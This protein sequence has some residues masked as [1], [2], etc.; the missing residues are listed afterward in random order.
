MALQPPFPHSPPPLGFSHLP[1]VQPLHAIAQAV[2]AAVVVTSLAT[3][4]AL[5]RTAHAQPAAR[6]EAQH[7]F[8]IPA[9]PLA[10]ALTAFAADAGV[11]VSAP[12]ALVQGKHTAGLQ[13][14]YTVREALERLLAG[15]NLQADA[16]GQ[17]GYVLRAVPEVHVGNAAAGATLAEVRV[18]A[19]AERLAATEG[20]G[21]YT[22]R[23]SST[24]T[25]LALSLRETPQSVTVFTRQRMDDQG[26]VLQEDMV[27]QTTGLTFAQYGPTGGD[28][29]F[30]FARGFQV[31]NFQVDGVN[32]LFS[33]YTGIFQTSDMAMFDRAE[34]VRGASGLMSGAGTPGA[35]IN[36]V[37]KRPTAE[38]LGSVK[39]TAGSWDFGRAE[40]DVSSPLN[41]AGSVRGRVV[42]VSQKRHSKV[43]YEEDKTSSLYGV[44]EVDLAPATLAT[45]GFS[46]QDYDASGIG[47]SGRPLFY[48]D[49]TRTNWSRSASSGARW[50]STRRDYRSV[51]ASLEHRLDNGWHLK[52]AYTRD[53]NSY[54]EIPGWTNEQ[55]VDRTTGA[56]AGL[57]AAWWAGR[58]KQDTLDF[59]AAGPF[60]LLGRQH[61][62]AFGAS[63]ARTRND[64]QARG[65]WSF[66]GWDSSIANLYT[67]DGN[68][69]VQPDNPALG[70]SGTRE[71]SSSAYGS[72]R[73]RPADALSV[74]LGARLTNWKHSDSYTDYATGET[75]GS[76]MAENGK[77]TPYVGVVLDLGRDWSLYGSYTDIFQAQSAVDVNGRTLAPVL[78]RSYELGVK[79]ELLDRR[80]QLSAAVYRLLQDN[81]AQAITGS[82][83]PDGSQAYRA[84]QGAETRGFELEANGAL[85]R[86]WNLSAGF[87]RNL[88][89][90]GQSQRLN[91]EIPRN[92]FKLFTTYRL[93]GLGRGLTVGGGARWQSGTWSDYSFL[94]LP[95]VSRAEQK[96]YAVADLMLQ[97]PLTAQLTLSAHL[98]NV[99]DKK[100][101][102]ISTSAYYGEARN[103]RV[104]L[105]MKF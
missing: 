58:P 46:A 25:G 101:Q 28:T 69:P 90:D 104:S 77:L 67:W 73:L 76:R 68:I 55:P 84:V 2:L 44:V 88:A 29:N 16:V 15:S 72:I 85:T 7:P 96:S 27:R 49:G 51:F 23:A 105:A 66:A 79:G 50:A 17:G 95:G 32:R 97:M 10:A 5:P 63:F 42:A 57:W 56:G 71:R 13:G 47:R 35:T 52:A 61:D 31:K 34:I 37:R 41:E 59:T 83:A 6:A 98:Y 92:T 102:A 3:A 53:Q 26:I 21:A 11:S 80:L 86:D 19:E 43:D 82:Y 14:R 12:P 24:A 93:A 20:T 9:G 45:V 99:F 65:R 54:D 81:V 70:D 89:R 4:A 1:R 62:A 78:G 40:V 103:L 38:F 64:S 75:S 87:A 8:Q 100:Y 22:A 18:T 30:Y 91:P 33:D 60:S 39:L 74:I 48:T 94:G 36:L